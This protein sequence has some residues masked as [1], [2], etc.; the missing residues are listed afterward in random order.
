M[1]LFYSQETV[2]KE[3]GR[4]TS[5]AELGSS[6]AHFLPLSACIPGTL[7]ISLMALNLIYI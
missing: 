3:G 4:A 7:L 5:W 1:D 6:E 2:K